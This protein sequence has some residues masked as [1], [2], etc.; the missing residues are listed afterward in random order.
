MEK[1][2]GEYSKSEL[3]NIFDI[4]GK[5]LNKFDPHLCKIL[6]EL[7][8]LVESKENIDAKDVSNLTLLQP[9]FGRGQTFISFNKA[10]ND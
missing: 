8:Q 3:I 10:F 4:I 5:L 7:K 6:M 1:K 9:M 2:D